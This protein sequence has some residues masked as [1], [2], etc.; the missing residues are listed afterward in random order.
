M[1]DPL[2]SLFLPVAL[3]CATFLAACTPDDLPRKPWREELTVIVVQAE[4]D[5]AAEFELQLVALFAKQLQLKTRLL[6]LPGNPSIRRGG[7]P[8]H[9]T[10]SLTVW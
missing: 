10:C 5:V 8:L 3:L 9:T 4:N 1:Y 7:V 2:R 6:S